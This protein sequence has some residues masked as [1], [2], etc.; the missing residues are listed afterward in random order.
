MFALGPELKLILM[1]SYINNRAKK[2]LAASAWSQV[3]FKVFIAFIL[4]QSPL[5]ACSG[6]HKMPGMH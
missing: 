5:Q 3:F 4:W 2:N 1:Y 6:M